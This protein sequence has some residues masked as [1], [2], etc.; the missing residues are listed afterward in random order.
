MEYGILGIL[1]VI[2]AVGFGIALI[3]APLKLFS[4]HK[5]LK[6]ILKEIRNQTK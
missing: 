4:I 5:T 2:G 3:I 1:I 6:L